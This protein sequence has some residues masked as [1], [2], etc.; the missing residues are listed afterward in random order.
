MNSKWFWS[1]AATI[2]REPVLGGGFG[3]E[4]QALI[5]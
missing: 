4:K 2:E 1:P 5:H 3:A